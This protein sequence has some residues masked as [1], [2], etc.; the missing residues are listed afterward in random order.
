MLYALG[1]NGSGQLGIGSGEDTHEPKK[2]LLPANFD[3]NSII[4]ITAGGNHT[5]IQT[6][7][8]IF[9]AGD[10]SNGRYPIVHIYTQSKPEDALRFRLSSVNTQF[11]AA[12]WEAS[13]VVDNIQRVFTC[14]TG[15]KGELGLMEGVTQAAKPN[16]LKNF[17]PDD[18]VLI[19]DLSASMSHT[20]CLFAN[21]EAYGWGS[22]RKGQLGESAQD[23]WSPRK[24]E[25]IP[26]EAHRVVCG[27]DFTYFIGSPSSGEHFIMG[28]DRWGVKSQAPLSLPPWKDVAASW[29]S[30]FVLLEDGTLL[31]WGRNDRGQLGPAG[32][33]KLSQIAVGSEHVVALTAAEKV[34]T[35]GWGEHGNCGQPLDE[36]G[37]VKGCWNEI[38]V[39]GNVIGVGAGCATT[40]II[41]E[42]TK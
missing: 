9:G 21:G 8:Q 42:E 16:L 37:D 13:T 2:C 3:Y 40:F 5:L 1:S 18:D 29:G 15:H 4:N 26:F 36:T 33:P 22:G 10:I 27:K 20:V 14:G 34:I 23:V 38:S 12:T 25:G 32:L 24:I 19:A 35:W 17:P 30:I 39:S 6:P 41:T 31:S 7:S 28:N 11:C